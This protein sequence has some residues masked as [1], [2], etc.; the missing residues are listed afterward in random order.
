MTHIKRS[1]IIWFIAL[2]ILP[3]VSLLAAC[4]GGDQVL[5]AEF[6]RDGEAEIFLAGLGD[7]ESEMQSLAEDVQQARLFEGQYATFV[8][9]TDRII[10]WY[11]DGD[12]LRIEQLESGDEA[13]TEVFEADENVQIF[14]TFTSDPFAIYLTDP[15]DFDNYRCYVSLDGAAADRLTRGG[16]CFATENG[17]VALEFERNGLTVTLVSLDGEEE[18]VILDEAEDVTDV[19]WNDDLSTF[20]YVELGR[21]DAQLFLIEPGDEEGVALGDEFALIESFGF[22]PDGK[23]V[24]IIGK[25]DEDDEEVGLFINGTEGALLEN[26]TIA[27]EGQSEDGD[28]VVFVTRNEDEATAFVYSVADETV[29]E[30]VEEDFVSVGGYVTNDRFLLTAG[31]IDD[32]ALLSARSDGSESVALFQDDDYTIDF[33]YLNVATEQL[34]LQLTDKDGLHALFV[35]GLEE[36]NGY[37]LLE[38]W[39]TLAVLNA[40][41]EYIVFA[42]RE[43]VEDDLVLYSILIEPDA[44]EIE[45]DDDG[46]LDFQRM[47][48]SADG[49]SIYYTVLKDGFNDT[50]VR[51]VPVDGSARPEELYR[52]MLLLDVSW[53][54]EPNLQFIR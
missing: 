34:L 40:S 28:Y 27:I 29:I 21:R 31:R 11:V 54:E 12:N 52:D 30:V 20:A 39:A 46:D 35:T 16:R 6:N 4:S 53:V 47:F 8:P 49:R 43:D 48:F 42:A 13:P 36:E 14:G 7:E 2:L 50:E 23:T 10:L 26:S 24:Y 25:L 3:A 5:L 51:L 15:Q 22:L 33:S 37:F 1:L 19:R 18:T 44:S 17:V 32:V 45:L 9:T 38:E 41:K